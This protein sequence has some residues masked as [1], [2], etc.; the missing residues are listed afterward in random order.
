MMQFRESDDDLIIDTMNKYKDYIGSI[1]EFKRIE[2]VIHKVENYRHEI[3]CIGEQ[4]E[5]HELA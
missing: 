5:I 2:H 4:C 3:E 1:E